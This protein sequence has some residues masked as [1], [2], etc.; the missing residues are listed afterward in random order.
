MEYKYKLVVFDIECDDVVATKIHCLSYSYTDDKGENIRG[1]LTNVDAIPD[2]LSQFKYIVGHNIVRYDVPVIEDLVGGSVNYKRCIDTLGLSWWLFPDRDKH[3]LAYWGADLGVAK[4]E[5]EDWKGQ[6]LEVYVHRCE[7][8]VRITEKL[9]FKNIIPKLN[10]IYGGDVET[11][12]RATEYVSFKMWCLKLQEDRP[13]QLNIERTEKILARFE[14]IVEEKREKLIEVMPKVPKMGIKVRPKKTHTNTGSHTKLYDKWLN[15]LA[16]NSLPEDHMEPVN[17][18]K[19]YEEPNPNSTK[20]KKDWLFS[21]GWKPATFKYDK[22][23]DGSMRE[24]PQIN[25]NGK[26]CSSIIMLAE[27]YEVLKELEGYSMIKSRASVLKGF[28]RD[29]DREGYIKASAH[30]FTNTMRLKHSILVNLPGVSGKNDAADGLWVRGCLVAEEGQELC[31]ADISSLEDSTKQHYMYPHD[32]EYVK[33][34]Q[35]GDYDPHI[36]IGM[37]ANLITSEEAQF[38]KENKDKEDLSPEDSKKLKVISN[39]RKQSKV[40]NFSAIYGVG[41]KKLSLSLGILKREAKKLLDS[42]WGINWSVEKVAEEQLVIK[43]GKEL[44]LKNPINGFYY[45]LRYKK[46]IFSTLNQGS[47]VYVFDTWLKYILE[48]RPQLSAQFHDEIVLQLL[49][50]HR[51]GCTRL[52]QWAMDRTNEELGLNVTINFDAA[53]GDSYADVH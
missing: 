13:L 28:L 4:P 12:R 49:K 39:I 10:A 53:Y 7:E 47:G 6:P 38:F 19:G 41:A 8:D 11:I 20:Q 5:V 24:I 43:V 9:F 26:L 2:F 42:Y 35:K 18:V 46:D 25:D 52:L 48:K 30:G 14:E 17:Y 29:V 36:A 34:M 51:E 1:T 22:Y 21:L 3:G 16:E 50:G 33:E 40:V 23:P 44:W 31:G 37:F 27:K 15:F 32:P 45:S